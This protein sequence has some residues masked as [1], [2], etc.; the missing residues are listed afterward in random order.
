MTLATALDHNCPSGVGS[1]GA[2]PPERSA[3]WTR[4]AGMA[5][6]WALKAGYASQADL[7]RTEEGR[8]PGRG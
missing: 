7:R 5:A 6:R 4:S 1:Q 2:Y 3:S 8:L